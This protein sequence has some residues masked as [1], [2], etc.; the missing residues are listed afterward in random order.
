MMP[1]WCGDAALASAPTASGERAREQESA[2]LRRTGAV[3]VADPRAFGACFYRRL[4]E[5]APSL[6]TLFPP[7]LQAQELKLA[8]MVAHLL[9]ALDRRDVLSQSLGELGRRHRG[10]GATFVH[11]LAVGEALIE[12]LAECNGADFDAQARLAWARLYSW[13]VYRMR[14]AGTERADRLGAITAQA[15]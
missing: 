3:V 14:Y 4:F 12:A 8:G 7:D 11:Y 9:G 10:Y 5:R 15:C 6:R 2:L 13:V 1:A